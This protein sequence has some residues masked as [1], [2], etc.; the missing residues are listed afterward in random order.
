MFT[1]ILFFSLLD[2]AEVSVLSFRRRA[3]IS[4]LENIHD[5]PVTRVCWYG[6]SQFYL[7]GCRYGAASSPSCNQ[8]YKYKDHTL[9]LRFVRKGEI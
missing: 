2:A 8:V 7:T 4:K 1:Q 3:V 6:R 9:I 5:S